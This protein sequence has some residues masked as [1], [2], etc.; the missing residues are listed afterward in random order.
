GEQRRPD[1]WTLVRLPA[2]AAL[3]AGLRELL[4]GVSGGDRGGGE[5]RLY[6]RVALG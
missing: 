4:R 2:E 6:G 3:R 1:L 5:A